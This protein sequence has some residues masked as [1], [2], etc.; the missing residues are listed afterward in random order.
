MPK[1]RSR[2]R[3]A[4]HHHRAPHHLL[5]SSLQFELPIIYN[6]GL[7][8]NDVFSDTSLFGL[9]PSFQSLCEVATSARRSLAQYV[10]KISSLPNVG[11]PLHHHIPLKRR[12]NFLYLACGKTLDSLL[13]AYLA[14]LNK[15]CKL[16]QGRNIVETGEVMFAWSD[17]APELNNRVEMFDRH[18]KLMDKK[19]V[20][21]D[22]STGDLVYI[23][24]HSSI[25]FERSQI[26][27]LKGISLYTSAS[28]KIH[29]MKD[30]E[31]AKLLAEIWH[32]LQQAAGVFLFMS[33][34]TI[35]MDSV[36]NAVRSI[37][38]H[39]PTLRV[40]ANFVSLQQQFVSLAVQI[41]K[42]SNHGRIA[43]MAAE[44]CQ[45]AQ[46]VVDLAMDIDIHDS[47][48][49]KP[50]IET[51]KFMLSFVRGLYFKAVGTHRAS[52]KKFGI[53]EIAMDMAYRSFLPKLTVKITLFESG[54]EPPRQA[55]KEV[56]DDS[57]T[58]AEKFRDMSEKNNCERTGLQQIRQKLVKD[59]A[60]TTTG[61]AAISLK[62][63]QDLSFEA[64]DSS[65]G[66]VDSYLVRKTKGAVPRSRSG[67]MNNDSQT[68]YDVTP[69]AKRSTQLKRSLSTI[70]GQNIQDLLADKDSRSS[71][72]HSLLERGQ[73]LPGMFT[74][75]STSTQYIYPKQATNK[76]HAERSDKKMSGADTAK[77][78]RQGVSWSSTSSGTSQIFFER[79]MT[80]HELAMN[81]VFLERKSVRPTSADMREPQDRVSAFVPSPRDQECA[82]CLQLYSRL[83]GEVTQNSIIQ[84][85]GERT[86]RPASWKYRP[87]RVCVFCLQFHYQE[88]GAKPKV[89][90][91][92]KASTL[93]TLFSTMSAGASNK[94]SS[95][96]DSMGRTNS[97]TMSSLNT[98]SVTS[99][100]SGVTTMTMS[101]TSEGSVVANIFTTEKD[102]RSKLRMGMSKS[103]HNLVNRDEDEAEDM[104]QPREM[105]LSKIKQERVLS[106]TR[107][108]KQALFTRGEIGAAGKVNELFYNM[109]SQYQNDDEYDEWSADLEE[110][111]EICGEL[112]CLHLFFTRVSIKPANELLATNMTME[113]SVN[114][115]FLLDLLSEG[116]H[117]D[118]RVQ[119]VLRSSKHVSYLMRSG[120]GASV[121][122][123]DS[124]NVGD[125]T[126]HQ[127]LAI[128]K[129]ASD[130]WE[131]STSSHL[132]SL[133]KM[134]RSM[135]MMNSS[136]AS[137]WTL[138][139][140]DTSAV[141]AEKEE[142]QR[143][144]DIRSVSEGVPGGGN[145]LRHI[146]HADEQYYRVRSLIES[147]NVLRVGES[148]KM[149]ANRHKKGYMETLVASIHKGVQDREEEMVQ[150]RELLALQRKAHE[151][152][153]LQLTSSER[154]K[155]AAEGGVLLVHKRKCGLC[156]R[157]FSKPNLPTQAT[158]GAIED[159]RKALE[160]Q[161]EK[162]IL[163][164]KFQ[165]QRVEIPDR[166]AS[167]VSEFVVVR[168][169]DGGRDSFV[170]VH[171][172]GSK[173]LHSWKAARR[174]KLFARLGQNNQ[175]DTVDD[176]T[177]E[178]ETLDTEETSEAHREGL[179]PGGQRASKWGRMKGGAKLFGGAMIKAKKR[180]LISEAEKR[181]R[182]E[183]ALE[184]LSALKAGS[185]ARRIANRDMATRFRKYDRIRLC[186]FCT[187]FYEHRVDLASKEFVRAKAPEPKVPT[188]ESVSEWRRQQKDAE[189]EKHEEEARLAAEEERHDPINIEHALAKSKNML[190]SIDR[191]P[192]LDEE[193]FEWMEEERG[194]Q[195]HFITLPEVQKERE[196]EEEEEV[197]D[198]EEEQNVVNDL[199]TALGM[200]LSKLG[201]IA[202][203][204]LSR[205]TLQQRLRYL[206]AVRMQ[207]CARSFLIRSRMI[208]AVLSETNALQAG[209]NE[210]QEQ[211]AE[212]RAKKKEIL[213]RKKKEQKKR[214]K[215]RAY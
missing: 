193:N 14:P 127:F 192:E 25:F 175:S 65:A 96:S 203:H 9:T 136:S 188:F 201:D 73:H 129:S 38:V 155:L 117:G 178:D 161:A 39:A 61:L 134:S 43:H 82:M 23:M 37:A 170:V 202:Y 210:F 130:P 151:L 22:K 214:K 123:N 30:Q 19:H 213:M 103:M 87:V 102:G 132:D 36:L 148:Q 92:A 108:P 137:Q 169:Y 8:F 121:R 145:H 52:G 147:M 181:A 83:P 115:S 71:D 62:L 152:G 88:G 90:T 97:V 81:G 187:Q 63:G 3:G 180:A 10:Q 51:S 191:L 183:A 94:D 212:L 126:Y 5:L 74:D 1:K 56:C 182:D 156:T 141:L 198:E 208:R 173:K 172:N 209:I 159:L 101:P 40:I 174:W 42:H 41:E 157:L 53:A 78:R 124:D 143:R 93:P 139:G 153:N 150:Q 185:K 120:I 7:Q 199:M 194:Q 118:W 11:T 200:N 111:F 205:A 112:K 26:F 110:Y 99:S 15:L 86:R 142:S 58:W 195:D 100:A 207:S 69:N 29:K 165:G 122:L 85:R 64:Y 13:D 184:K 158:R 140:L 164:S 149:K 48:E 177:E 35:K 80:N 46:V 171:S 91:K 98:S 196:E 186:V 113:G 33:H 12:T 32:A 50:L 204:K 75:D 189:R 206:G 146:E 68:T 144:I 18:S 17:M 168:N 125:I 128:V 95:M 133:S 20:E 162:R 45:I 66:S 54:R 215:Q 28:K 176:D 84:F 34:H 70:Q 154:A 27:F 104:R 60:E 131:A 167:N 179:P 89:A 197:M 44:F 67:S 79:I 163:L 47:P 72:G 190:R 31:S 106:L 24:K 21:K 211:I 105:R 116:P 135:M 16:V 114:L 109:A 55:M 119:N 2:K 49:S 76:N 77:S 59:L 6:E 57:Y 166:N 160:E 138:P 107:V 4:Q